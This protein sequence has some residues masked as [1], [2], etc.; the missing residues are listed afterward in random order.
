MF[1]GKPLFH[2]VFYELPEKEREDFTAS[3]SKLLGTLTLP[4]SVAPG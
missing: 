1:Q 3:S 2:F 4:G